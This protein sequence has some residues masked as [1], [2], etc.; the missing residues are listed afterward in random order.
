MLPQPPRLQI[1]VHSSIL[2]IAGVAI[3]FTATLHDTVFSQV[4]FAVAILA[5]A[6]AEITLGLVTKKGLAPVTLLRTAVA[7]VSAVIL[8]ATLDN[9]A[10]FELTVTLWA[11]V[12]A[13]IGVWFTWKVSDDAYAREIRNTAIMAG[14]LAVLVVVIPGSPASV[15]G[16][17]GGYCFVV[18][19]YL[20]IAAFDSAKS[21]KRE[22]T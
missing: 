12:T 13:I 5:A 22:T 9:F 16:L 20:A 6:I 14:L 8:F 7:L 3:A 17:Y 4:L 10:V 1:A 18:G 11:A 21:S 15:I 2:L 19:V